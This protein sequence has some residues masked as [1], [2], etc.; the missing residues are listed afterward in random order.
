MGFIVGLGLLV[1]GAIGVKYGVT[2]IV[3]G[4]SAVLVGLGLKKD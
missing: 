4:L 3:L 2:A 1:I